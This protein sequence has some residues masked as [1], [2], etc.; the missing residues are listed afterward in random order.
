LLIVATATSLTVP[1]LITTFAI[2]VFTRAGSAQCVGLVHL[3]DIQ[4]GGCGINADGANN[5]A[6]AVKSEGTSGVIAVASV[7][8]VPVPTIPD[9]SIGLSADGVKAGAGAV[10]SEFAGNEFGLH[11]I[12][13]ASAV[14]VEKH[15]VALCYCA[16]Y[17]Y[18]IRLTVKSR[19]VYLVR[20]SRSDGEVCACSNGIRSVGR[21]IGLLGGGNVSYLADGILNHYDAGGN[22]AAVGVDFGENTVAAKSSGSVELKKNIVG[23]STS[24]LA[25]GVNGGSGNRWYQWYQR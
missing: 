17:Y 21:A 3:S 4:I 13:K 14:S 1:S 9:L 8:V 16:G 12:G 20:G 5:I 11:S 15:I 23:C 2:T 18:A 25:I 22:A 7:A 6:V 24:R 19:G 10:G